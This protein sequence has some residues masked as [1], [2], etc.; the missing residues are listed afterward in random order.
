M[1][2][3]NGKTYEKLIVDHLSLHDGQ[4]AHGTA[5]SNG[6]APEPVVEEEENYDLPF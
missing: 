5:K 4:T 1:E 3:Y 2:D 6:Y